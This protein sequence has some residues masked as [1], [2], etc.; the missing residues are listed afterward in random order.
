MK[1]IFYYLNYKNLFQDI[2]KCGFVYSWK[3]LVIS[4]VVALFSAIC[5]GLLFRLDWIQI[6]VILVC[7]GLALPVLIVNGYNSSYQQRRFSDVNQYV[8]QMLYYFKAN[9]YLI[10]DSLTEIQKL[11]PTGPMRAAIEKGI[12]HIKQGYDGILREGALQFIEEEYPCER[13]RKLHKFMISV[14]RNGG[15][16][17]GP[18]G[19]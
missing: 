12:L 3:K 11:F 15:K 10:L 18:R 13:V 7:A 19:P 2:K 5:I 8:E 16:C 1:R 14:N 9:N 6:A 17:D 4:Y